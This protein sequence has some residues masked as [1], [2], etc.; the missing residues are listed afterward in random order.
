[1][2]LSLTLSSQDITVTVSGTDI[3]VVLSSSTG[4]DIVNDTSPQ[5]GAALDC[6]GYNITDVQELRTDASP[7][8][9]LTAT[10]PTTNS[11]NAGATISQSDLCYLASDGEWAKADADAASTASGMLAIA[12]AAGTDGNA[13]LVALPGSFVRDDSWNWTIGADLYVSTTPG[14]ITE[15]APSGSADIVRVVG[16]A[17]TADIVYFQPSGA[18]VEVA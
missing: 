2:T 11:I 6:N 14:G 5:L 8:T 16:Y 3:S 17:V 15:T 4:V 7:D 10:G 9:D 1:M 18:F 13:M 12:L